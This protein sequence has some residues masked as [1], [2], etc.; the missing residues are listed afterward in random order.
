MS[1]TAPGALL[2]HTEPPG[3]D[4]D[5]TTARSDHINLMSERLRGPFLA[6]LPILRPYFGSLVLAL[7]A[8]AIAIPINVL[9]DVSSLSRI[10][11]V[12]VLM[13]A[14]SYGLWPAMFA[15]LISVVMYDFFFLPPIYSLAVH[16]AADIVN[17]AFFIVIA[18]MVSGLAARV[19]RFAVLADKRALTAEKLSAFT[20]RI[21]GALTVEDVLARSSE[22]IAASIGTS[23]VTMLIE[24][25]DLVRNSIRTTGTEP[26]METI[27]RLERRLAARLAGSGTFTVDGWHLLDLLC[28]EMTSC[29]VGVRL[30][31]GS[32]TLRAEE[33]HL[34]QAF[35][36]QTA[37]AIKQNRL[38]QRLNDVRIQIESEKFATALLNSIS[39]D[40]RGPLTTILGATSAL[41]LHWPSLREAGK[42]ELVKTARHE[43]EHLSTYV[44]NLLDLTRIEF[45]A[46]GPKLIPLELA[47]VVGSAIHK[48]RGIQATHRVKID[49]S[50]QLPLVEADAVLLQQTIVNLLDNAAK[51]SP[52]G[53]LIGIAADANDRSINLRIVDEGLGLPVSDLDRVFDKFF[54]SE[55]TRNKEPGT[56]LGLTICRGLI[57]AMNGTIEACNRTDRS[58]MCISVTLPVAHEIQLSQ[59][60]CE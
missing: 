3:I 47:D 25:N 16:S 54:R 8:L 46:I 23:A 39:H 44:N 52:R 18:V 53:S 28:D 22:D 19:R 29:L 35:A 33:Q 32:R 26:T 57:E 14:I 2:P 1:D 59:V 60:E 17:M 30:P 10:F 13:S 38:R 4:S 42:I 6:V 15:A 45:G 37:S 9:L 49:V 51:Y 12:A 7:A 41:E 48:A 5:D 40:L 43:S 50:D 55:T 27:G 11:L 20:R 56:G 36:L 34:L 58:G 21:G 24:G 31:W